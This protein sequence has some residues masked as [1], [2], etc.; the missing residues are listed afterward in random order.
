MGQQNAFGSFI[1]R[2]CTGGRA[3]NI[4]IKNERDVFYEVALPLGTSQLK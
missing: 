4:C 1:K 3:A 2:E